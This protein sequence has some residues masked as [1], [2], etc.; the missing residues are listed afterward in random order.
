MLS[1][2]TRSEDITDVAPDDQAVRRRLGT[3]AGGKGGRKSTSSEP[4]P[5]SASEDHFRVSFLVSVID[6]ERDRTIGWRN[7]ARLDC[8]A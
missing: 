7:T 4:L 6:L 1:I 3:D 8:F 2:W 5:T